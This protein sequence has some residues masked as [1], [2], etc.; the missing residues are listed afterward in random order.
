[1]KHPVAAEVLP[2]AFVIL[3]SKQDHCRYPDNMLCGAA[4]AWK[5]VCALIESGQFKDK[6]P[7]GFEK[8]LLD[9]VGI[10]T[11]ADMVPL[12]NE[13]RVLAHYG[14]K[15]LRKTRRPGLL[16]LFR[17]SGLKPYSLTEDDIGFT[18]APRINA[19]SRMDNPYLAFEL[20]SSIDDDRTESLASE[21]NKLNDVR[22]GKVAAMVKEMKHTLDNRDEIKNVIVLGNPHWQPALLGLAAM[23]IMEKHSRPVFLWGREGNGLLKGSARSDGSINLVSMM[24][25][26]REGVLLGFGGHAFSGGFSVIENEIHFLEEHF[27][28]AFEKTEKNTV[29]EDVEIDGVLSLD[30]VNDSLYNSISLL[31]PFGVDNPKP[32]FMFQGV[33]P[34]KIRMFGKNEEHLEL[35][36]RKTNGD[37]VRAIEFFSNRDIKENKKIDLVA[38]LEKSTFGRYPELRLRIVDIL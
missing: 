5:L 7:V 26:V 36:F 32:M 37:F 10:S 9:L 12:K 15:V 16:K 38:V 21:L 29:D 19:A 27:N 4:V 23:N 24:R 11:V 8:W 22:K 33:T 20:L 18:I 2:D 13:N 6:V 30:E 1:L 25:N 14:L 17:K 3:N 31:A 34:E 35:T 28:E